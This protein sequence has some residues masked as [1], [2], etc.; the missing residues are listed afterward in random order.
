M[1]MAERPKTAGAAGDVLDARHWEEVEEAV[2]LLQEERPIEAILELRR[3]L[4]D[5]PRN[6]YAYHFLGVALYE[7]SELEASRDA[8]RAAVAIAP[9]YLGA[10]VH[11]SHVLRQLGD[12]RGAIEQA[13]TAR[14][15]APEDPEV[16]HALGLAH[17]MRGDKQAAWKWLTAFLSSNPE[18]EVSLEVRAALE[19]LGPPPR[20]EED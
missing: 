16:W 14:R 19:R 7:T 13:E 9:R 15:Q 8:Y 6:P 20:D 2:E 10:R 17:A 5:S 4:K 18:F 3:I 12:P 1:A 11:L